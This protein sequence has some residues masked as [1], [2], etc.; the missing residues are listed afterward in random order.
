[1]LPIAERIAHFIA[2]READL[3]MTQQ[4]K[5]C[6]P[7]GGVKVDMVYRSPAAAELGRLIQEWRESL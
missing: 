7:C 2:D 5:F 4:S 3:L 6:G 1:M